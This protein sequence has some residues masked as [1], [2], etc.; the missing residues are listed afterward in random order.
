VLIRDFHWTY[1]YNRMH[2]KRSLLN[3]KWTLYKADIQ[4]SWAFLKL[5]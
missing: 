3:Q 5:E 1:R 4:S 2:S